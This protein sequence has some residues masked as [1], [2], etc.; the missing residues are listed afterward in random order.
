VPELQ[1][2]EW[3]EFELQLMS[4]RIVGLAIAKILFEERKFGRRLSAD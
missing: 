3:D 2:L 4:A 1:N